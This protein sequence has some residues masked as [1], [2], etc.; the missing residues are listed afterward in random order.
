VLLDA[1]VKK[2]GRHVTGLGP[3]DFVVEEEGREVEVT[4]ATYYGTPDELRSS[5]EGEVE[6]SDRLFILFF[7]DRSRDA[8]FLRS[9]LLDAGQQATRWVEQELLPND[10][11]A[12]LVYDVRL[13]VMSDFTRDR[14]ALTEA[15][16]R[17]VSARNEPDRSGG[18]SREP[19]RPAADSPSLLL[20]LPAGKDLARETRVFELTLA[21]L[22]RAAEGIVGRKNLMLFSVG[23]GDVDSFGMWTPDTRYYPQLEQNLNDGNVAVYAIDMVGGRRLGAATPGIASS[24]TAIA[25]DTN[26]LYYENFTSFSTPM[27]QVLEDTQ[28][29]YLLSFRSEYPRGTSGYREVRVRMREPGMNV[30]ARTGYL[31]GDRDPESKRRQDS[32]E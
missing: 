22:G 19:L 21:L 12:V 5:G 8:P 16:S 28:G 1:I 31:Y 24:L 23:F 14:A 18:R 6:R 15:I 20:N 26:G 2:N 25:D 10:Q 11:V 30:R 27:R 3:D 17:A 9:L 4:S 7:H 29:Y 32:R 13:K